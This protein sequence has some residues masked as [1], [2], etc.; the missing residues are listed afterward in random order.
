MGGAVSFVSSGFRFQSSRVLRVEGLR[1]AEGGG[2]SGSQ[3]SDFKFLSRQACSK[4]G[5]RDAK[6][7]KM[8]PRAQRNPH[9][10]LSCELSV[11]MVKKDS[12]ITSV[13]S[14]TRHLA[15]DTLHPGLVLCLLLAV[16][17]LLLL[18]HSKPTVS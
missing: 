14:N 6:R 18:F 11:S 3:V 13:R 17:C 2:S 7:A 5:R 10:A 9:S 16:H 12:E 15:L 1:T 4:Q 8:R